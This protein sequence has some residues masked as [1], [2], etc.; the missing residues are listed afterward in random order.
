MQWRHYILAIL[1][2]THEFDI[3]IKLLEYQSKW[4]RITKI[5]QELL[6]MYWEKA[7]WPAYF[8]ASAASTI[9]LLCCFSHPKCLQATVINM[10]CVFVSNYSRV[11]VLST[12]GAAPAQ[13][14]P[15]ILSERFP[16]SLSLSWNS[17][18]G[19]DFYTLQM[20]DQVSVNI[21]VNVVFFP[22]QDK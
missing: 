19:D 22:L 7:F 8:S 16:S 15:P 9:M 12:C 14:D 10:S 6:N 13:P 3:W 18:P 1:V 20:D 21:F 2:V 17:R 5:E 11:A 4:T